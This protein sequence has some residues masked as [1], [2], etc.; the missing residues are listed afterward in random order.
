MMAK[1]KSIKGC[2]ILAEIT[3]L[4]TYKLGAFEKLSQKD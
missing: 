4:K 1:A 3:L 2:Q